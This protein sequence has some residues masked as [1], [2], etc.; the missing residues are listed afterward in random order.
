MSDDKPSMMGVSKER[1]K[2]A[3][4]GPSTP[5]IRPASVAEAAGSRIVLVS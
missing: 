2:V 1:I 3:T 5:G 4:G